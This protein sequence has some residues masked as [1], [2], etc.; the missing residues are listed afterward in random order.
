MI[1]MMMSFSVMAQKHDTV[2]KYDT[3][4]LNRRINQIVKIY[5][6]NTKRIDTLTT[7]LGKLKENQTFLVGV[8][9]GYQALK[10]EQKKKK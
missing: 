3:N 2:V 1:M 4:D 5:N 8:I 10:D 9:Q 7:Q 6:D